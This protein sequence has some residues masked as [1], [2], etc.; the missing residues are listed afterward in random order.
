MLVALLLGLAASLV[1]LGRLRRGVRAPVRR[2]LDAARAGAPDGT[3][4]EVDLLD[5]LERLE[6]AFNKM[7]ARLKA[8]TATLGQACELAGLGTWSILPDLVSVRGSS[9]IGTMLGF[10]EKESIVG[11]DAL[12]NRI[13][14]EDR[15][16]FDAALA[17]AVQ[18]G[19]MADVEFRALDA[20]EDVR[21]F[22]ARTGPGGAM[23][24]DTEGGISGII[25][26]ITDLRHKEAALTK[27]QTLE[28]LA[29]EVAHIGGWRFEIATRKFTG[30]RE[31]AK[32][33]GLDDSW[34][35]SIDDAID[36]L[37][38]GEGR[39]RMERSFWTC[40]GAGIRYD[41]IAKYTKFDGDETWL[42]VIGEAERDESG[43]IIGIYG[44]MQDVGELVRARS[45]T[46]DVRALLRKILDD[47]NDGFVILDCD[48]AIQYMN[49]KAHGILGVPDR[50]L[51][52]GN[53]WHDIP[54]ARESQ[55]ER[56]VTD[57]LKTGESQN[58]EG[59]ITTPDQW[60]NVAVHPTA[61]GIGIYLNDMT[62]DREA[63]V[64]LRLLDAAM[65]EVSDVVLI[66][67]AM[68][69]DRPGPRVV[70]VN[71]AFVSTTG[72]T[73]E[74]ILG[75]T[76]RILQGPETEQEPLREIRKA[77]EARQPVRTEL[78]NY[79]KDGSR[80]TAEININ[81]LFDAE[82]ECTHFVGVQ[83]DTTERREKEEHLRAREEQFRL[84]SR[85]SQDIIWDWDMR[86]G[87]MWNSRNSEEIFGVA[88]QSLVENVFE[89]RIENVLERIHP[90]DRLKITESLDA[91]LAGNAE[92]WRCEYRVKAQDGSWRNITDKGFIVRDDDGAP[93]R[94]VGAM[95]DLTDLRALDAQLHQSQKLET[96]GQLTGG[97][98]HDFNNL[99]TVILGNCDILLD[100]IDDDSPLRPLLQSIEDA[101]ERGARVS[102]DLLAFSR[103]QSLELRPTDINE[104][105][106]RSSSLFE[107]VI[108]ASV[109]L[110]YD[111][112]EEPTIA[113]VDPD[114]LQA[115]L[116]NLVIN[117]MAAIPEQ[118]TITVRT[119]SADDLVTDGDA[120]IA[121][122]AYI[123]IDVEDDGSGMSPD[124]AE[125]AFEP[126]FTTKEPGAGTGMG[127]SS[128][129]GLVKQSD[130]D[131][132]IVSEPGKG[133]TVTLR[134]PVAHA[135]P[136]WDELAE[137]AAP[138]VGAGY[139]I[140]V[141]E[142]DI[143]LR[144]FVHNVLTRMGYD[145]V[146]AENGVNALEILKKNDDFD[147]V[148]TDIVM[149]GGVTGIQLAK[150]AQEMYPGL[151][152][153]FTSGY[154][155]DALPKERHLP[156]DIPM[157]SKPFRTSELVGKVEA[158]LASAAAPEE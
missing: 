109:D 155:H 15:A 71:D 27:S 57:A 25:Q 36:R 49:R 29:G 52:G 56:V 140:L 101:A 61:S 81:P 23:P 110:R 66:T 16:A 119:R 141:V 74:E 1:A 21:V 87:I 89:G 133:T 65:K 60:V 32:L 30:T 127:L 38:P 90:D 45:A 55:L 124:V 69:L 43:T 142:D 145:I 130:G 39:A 78:T 85:A 73:Q 58:F 138:H 42:R 5:N 82:G 2:M 12:R 4:Q 67:D 7:S 70:F 131:A 8:R 137:I 93:R 123:E 92:T 147:L 103:R 24:D 100:D 10:S 104:L 63:R 96:V 151:K 105:V 34:R 126:F 98:A 152:I 22:R 91:A 62:E 54:R 154:A 132:S 40:V 13:L 86:T 46:E 37:V 117:A 106:R 158:A 128:V 41:E 157:L 47:L 79:R 20:A 139:R 111:L 146:E 148:F 31:T 18:E 88:S 75:D 115:A 44:A 112:T 80:F 149:P 136:A 143:E 72:Y 9:H 95:S 94:M 6:A 14:P 113:Q 150:E 28:R 129:Y 125:R 84:A 33:V 108:N 121:P 76:P 35:S 83:R 17:R 3:A 120:D 134:L 144:S 51:I 59:E 107:R 48:G 97:I 99:L 156:S 102:T 118:G 50:D 53:I 135:P 64:R 19:R 116:L 114:K 26:D 11:L 122:D 153:L 77:L 68:S